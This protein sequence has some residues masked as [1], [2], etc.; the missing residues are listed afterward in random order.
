MKSPPSD[1]IP[2][3][4]DEKYRVTTAQIWALGVTISAQSLAWNLGFAAGFGSFL[5]VSLLVGAAY[6]CLILCLGEVM[7]ALPFAGG[8][9]GLARCTLGFSVG[10]LVAAFE[11]VEY[12]AYTATAMMSFTSMLVHI[13]PAAAIYQPIVWFLVYIFCLSIHIYGA[14]AFWRLNYFFTTVSLVP[15]IIWIMG[16]IPYLDYKTQLQP[17][18]IFIDGFHGF[19]K[20]FPSATWLF[21][22]LEALNTAG[23]EITDPRV[24]VP[25]GQFYAMITLFCTGI[26]SIII[27]AGLPPG[28]Q[29][30][31]DVM[32]T[33]NSGFVLMFHMS[34]VKATYFSLLG[35]VGTL[36]GFI[37]AYSK[38]LTSVGSSNLISKHF[39]TRFFKNETPAISLVMGAVVA[40]L[41]CSMMYIWPDTQIPL[42]NIC[43]LSAAFAYSTQ[44]YG[45]IF[46]KKH[47]THLNRKFHS[48]FGVYGAYF[49]MSVW[50]VQI[51]SIAF[52]QD[53][54]FAAGGVF[55]SLLIFLYLYYHAVAKHHQ[56]FS[57]EEEKILFSTHVT[58][59]N[60]Q[61]S[62][63]KTSSSNPRL[64][65]STDASK[66]STLSFKRSFRK[67]KSRSKI[68]HVDAR[69]SNPN[70]GQDSSQLQER[71]SSPSKPS[72]DNSRAQYESP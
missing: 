22:G 7:S 33:W 47:F 26:T 5:I 53:D 49:S 58:A 34:D 3:S 10:F 44:C 59:F 48:P 20:A 2:S 43:M 67:S 62:K 70:C 24:I 11:I 36:Y 9:Y 6:V 21:V 63:K 35:T 55:L 57:K 45:Y 15:C 39:Q 54:D 41:L 18:V 8:A 32:A 56:V 72:Q 46:L 19:M 14:A 61:R 23:D 30:W 4:G 12:I 51:I 69:R 42:D 31:P 29:A 60:K 52:F 40:Y 38:L 71:Q 13:A 68:I 25:R 66:R 50:V 37:F 64:R 27:S 1:A 28:I 65:S 17:D 16:S